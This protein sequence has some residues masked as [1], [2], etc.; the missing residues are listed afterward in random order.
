MS[1]DAPKKVTAAEMKKVW[2][3]SKI[4]GIENTISGFNY[5]GDC[6]YLE[7]YIGKET[8]VFVP[9]NIGKYPVKQIGYS[10]L[11]SYVL[12]VEFETGDLEI[13][14]SFKKCTEMADD[15]GFITFRAG[16]RVIAGGY[17]GDDTIKTLI[18]P[19]GITEIYQEAFSRGVPDFPKTGYGFENVIIPEGITNIGY[20]A[21]KNCP[22]LETVYLP[23]TLQYFDLGVFLYCPKL[24]SIHISEN[25]KNVNYLDRLNLNNIVLFSKKGS[26]VEAYAIKNN[27]LFEEATD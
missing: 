15:S 19:E 10:A 16:N 9:A 27:C 25:A 8:H 18:I 3:L 17:V 2:K 14:C 26:P 12:S 24:K 6:Y 20:H 4:P 22:E 7:K 5:N 21:F 1:L 23:S 11:P 13:C